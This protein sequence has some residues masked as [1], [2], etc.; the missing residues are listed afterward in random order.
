MVVFIHGNF[1]QR[2]GVVLRL[3]LKSDILGLLKI[4]L[5]LATWKAVRC[6]GTWV[7]PSPWYGNSGSAKNNTKF[8]SICYEYLHSTWI[9]KFYVTQAQAIESFDQ[10]KTKTS[11]SP[12]KLGPLTPQ[13]LEAFVGYQPQSSAS[14]RSAG[15]A[16][17]WKK[18]E[19]CLTKARLALLVSKPRW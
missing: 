6:W 16:C 10:K 11:S 2:W 1:W 18:H 4:G 14:H 5:N 7:K 8:L 19:G 17:L 9:V 12:P 3:L 15:T 13:I